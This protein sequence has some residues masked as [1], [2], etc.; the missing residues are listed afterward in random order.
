[1]QPATEQPTYPVFSD[2]IRYPQHRAT[3]SGVGVDLLKQHRQTEAMLSGRKWCFRWRCARDSEGKRPASPQLFAGSAG[4]LRRPSAGFLV[5]ITREN[6]RRVSKPSNFTS[7]GTSSCFRAT[8]QWQVLA[9]VTS[10]VH[11][12]VPVPIFLEGRRPGFQEAEPSFSDYSGAGDVP[13]LLVGPS[14]GKRRREGSV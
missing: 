9:M 1:L 10:R 4:S 13:S 6:G 3:L 8:G 7:T 11:E 14:G 5:Y 2:D 12:N